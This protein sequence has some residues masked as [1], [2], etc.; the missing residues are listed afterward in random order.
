MPTKPADA[1]PDVTPD[2]TP[3]ATP[4]AAPVAA[5]EPAI[6]SAPSV[7]YIVTHDG[8]DSWL[9]GEVLTSEQLAG[10]DIDRLLR[11]GAIA[12]HQE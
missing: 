12:T 5:L 3:A 4:D 7:R 6:V 2:V 8:L 11:L 1:A 10:I 9:K